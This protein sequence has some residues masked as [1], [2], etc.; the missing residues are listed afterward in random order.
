MKCNSDYWSLYLTHESIEVTIFN[1]TS[2]LNLKC[3]YG[4]QNDE[5]CDIRA[6]GEV[7]IGI[8]SINSFKIL[9][10]PRCKCHIHHQYDKS[11]EKTR[12]LQ[13]CELYGYKSKE[14]KLYLG[15]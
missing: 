10:A 4:D 6:Y 15:M 2:K 14:Y 13:E 8:G 9:R 11:G 1:S 7:Q 5:D 12:N 3:Y